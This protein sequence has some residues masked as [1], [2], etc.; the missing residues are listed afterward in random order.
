MQL[1]VSDYLADTAH[2]NAAQNG[3]YLLLLMNYCEKGESL[4][5]KPPEMVVE[6]FIESA[7]GWVPSARHIKKLNLKRGNGLRPPAYLWEEIRKRIFQRDNYTCKYCGV[8][9][10]RLECDHIHPVS[11]G[12]SNEDFNLT[13][14]CFRCNRSKRDK[15][16]TEWK[17][18]A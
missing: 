18:G 4:K 2:L 3:A 14:A 17:T 12:G 11:K 5:N 6:F 9:G 1:Y 13:T 8:R 16:L 7:D 10:G 15:T